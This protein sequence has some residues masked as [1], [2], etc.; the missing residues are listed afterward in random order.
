MDNP[1]FPTAGSLATGHNECQ[2]KQT[3]L[4]FGEARDAAGHALLAKHANGEYCT[5]FFK[6]GADWARAHTLQ[7]E[8][9]KGLYEAL[10]LAE[11]ILNP[12]PE[13]IPKAPEYGPHA[14]LANAMIV[15]MVK[16]IQ[17]ALKAFEESSK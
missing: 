7:N 6:A 16:P 1:D 10:K 13:V 11:Q 5:D 14:K 8:P 9:A 2:G 15:E 17:E 12:R 3:D 4:A